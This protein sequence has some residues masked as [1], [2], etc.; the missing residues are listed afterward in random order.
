[1]RT[2]ANKPATAR[3]PEGGTPN[4]GTPNDWPLKI[5]SLLFGGF[6]GLALLK[7]P[8]PPVVDHLIT[9]PTNEWEWALMSWPV[10]FAYPLLGLLALAGL[11]LIRWP[12]NISKVGA[13]LPLAWLL[14]MGL[15]VTQTIDAAVSTVTLVHFALCV[16]CFYL[17]LLAVGRLKQ[18]GWLFAGLIV[19]FL[20]VLASGLQ[21]HFGGLE[22]TRKSFWLY[23]YP[24]L[25]EPP[26]PEL[27]KRMKSERIFST[28]FY[29]NSLAGLL[30]LLTPFVLGVIADARERFTIEARGFMGVVVGA[31][32]AGCLVWSGS[33]AGWLLALAMSVVILLR[34]PVNRQ[35]KIAVIVVLVLAG[36][37]GFAVRYAGFFKRGAPSVVERF[38]YWN[39]AWQNVQAHP[40][41]GSGPGTFATV[42]KR[43]K[44]PEAEMA[45][46]THN[47]YLQ[48]ASDSGLVAGLLFLAITVWVCVRTRWVWSGGGWGR[49]GVWLGLVGFAAQAVVEFG[50]YVPATAWCWFALAGWLVA[51]GAPNSDSAR[52]QSATV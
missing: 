12:R 52:S 22:A 40:L 11:A 48:Q 3:P 37:A 5:F 16:V 35:L 20:F 49:F 10:R 21:Q 24:P 39:A 31:A 6:L 18:A 2:S 34:L 30:L 42:Y 46:L 15:S 29:P 32:A 7:F 1:M 25:T 28:L 45:R 44:P 23:T 27:L 14:W 50:F 36:T 41:L 8:N 51:Q 13:C 33:K 38:N 9:V 43:V 4:G 17:G 26:P 47:D 19:A